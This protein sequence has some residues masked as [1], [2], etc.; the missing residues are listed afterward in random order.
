MPPARV[1]QSVDLLVQES[2]DGL[3]FERAL[4]AG[5]H[6]EHEVSVRARTV[7]GEERVHLEDALDRYQYQFGQ[8]AWGYTFLDAY[9]EGPVLFAPDAAGAHDPLAERLDA[10]LPRRHPAAR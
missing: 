10:A 6:E 3:P 9:P 2:G 4:G 8:T 1:D 7:Q 5:A